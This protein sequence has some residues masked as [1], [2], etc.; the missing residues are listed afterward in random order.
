MLNFFC[1]NEQCDSYS[2][3]ITQPLIEKIAGNNIVVEISCPSCKEVA[4]P[5]ENCWSLMSVISKDCDDFFGDV[6]QFCSE[7]GFANI[8]NSA[9]RTFLDLN[10]VDFMHLDQNTLRCIQKCI[11]QTAYIEAKQKELA[12]LHLQIEE[13]M[14]DSAE[15]EDV[16]KRLTILEKQVLSLTNEQVDFADYKVMKKLFCFE[17]N[18]SSFTNTH[19]N[20]LNSLYSNDEQSDLLASVQNY[21][22]NKDILMKSKRSFHFSDLASQ[23]AKLIFDQPEDSDVECTTLDVP[24]IAIDI[25]ESQ[26]QQNKSEWKDKCQDYMNFL[27]EINKHQTTLLKQLSSQTQ[28]ES[29]TSLYALSDDFFTNGADCFVQPVSSS[30]TEVHYEQLTLLKNKVQLWRMLYKSISTVLLIVMNVLDVNQLL[31]MTHTHIQKK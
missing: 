27:S 16:M 4:F 14:E 9:I 8:L 29:K 19:L 10:R 6:C 3:C 28:N 7:C 1:P 21:L 12:D 15:N 31:K 5:C 2:S 18:F 13:S 24:K 11:N 22:N 23:S 25:F 26:K 17:S 30:G 20:M